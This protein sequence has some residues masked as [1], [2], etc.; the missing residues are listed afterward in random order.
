MLLKLTGVMLIIMMA[1]GGGF[2]W[3][4]NNTQERLA[5]L[6]ANNAKLEAANAMAEKTINDINLNQAIANNELVKINKKFS[7]IRAQNSVLAKKLEK[8]DIGV[9]GAA[10][11]KL[12]ERVINKAVDKS[13]RCIELM[14]G[15]TL[16]TAELNAKSGKEF[17]S[18]CPWLWSGN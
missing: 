3:Y 9:L 1:M 11:P 13:L 12:V 16:T 17:N 7:A 4:Y 10:K 8:H 14:S 15:A 18:E 2:Y 6:N 5:I